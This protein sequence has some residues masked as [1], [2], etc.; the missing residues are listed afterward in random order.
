MV[1]LYKEN[2]K[3]VYDESEIIN[4]LKENSMNYSSFLNFC[5]KHGAG[6][7]NFQK[8]FSKK[9]N[10]FIKSLNWDLLPN[11]SNFKK[12]YQ[13]Y[14][15]LYKKFMIEG[16]NSSEI[17]EEANCSKRV[18]E[19]WLCEKHRIK[20]KDRALNLKLNEKQS[21]LIIGSLLGDGHIDKRI[22]KPIF[23][24]S[25]AENQKDY[26]YWKYEILKNIT[27]KEPSIINSMIKNFKNKPYNCQAQYRISTRIVFDLIR[28]RDMSK[29]E[30]IGCLDDFSLSVFFLDDAHRAKSSWELCIASF[31][32]EDKLFF[33]NILKSKFCLTGKLRND[34]RYLGFS[35]K[36]SKKI[37][38]MI[39]AQIDN[40]LD[41]IKK[42]ITKKK[43]EV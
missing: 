21:N 7:S 4:Y 42:K 14:D 24:V 40:D 32:N 8:V 9:H 16:K 20:S 19:K 34:N 23:I 5:K 12:I 33:I 2:R 6:N 10:N 37:D 35:S 41:I 31:S 3:W 39:L 22:D 18:I 29:Q 38:E 11:N 25:H 26:L 17:A 36:D 13:D 28:Y 1:K 30:L 27:N 43:K 15:W